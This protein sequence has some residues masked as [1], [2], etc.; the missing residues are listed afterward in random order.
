MFV[1]KFYFYGSKP[2]FHLGLKKV[3]HPK[4]YKGCP[5]RVCGLKECSSFFW[6]LNSCGYLMKLEKNGVFVLTEDKASFAHVWLTYMN[7]LRSYFFKFR[8]YMRLK[9]LGYRLTLSDDSKSLSLIFGKNLPIVFNFTNPAYSNLD[10]II[11]VSKYSRVK[12]SFYV[13][14]TNYFALTRFLSLLRKLTKPDVYNAKGVRFCRERFRV[15]YRKAF[16]EF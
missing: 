9:G 6:H 2:L 5:N 4:N 14:C 3:L 12:H 10:S 11:K 16:G 1:K 7:Y 13:H 15:K 8:V